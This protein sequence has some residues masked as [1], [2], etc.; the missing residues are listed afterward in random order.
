M[1]KAILIRVGIGVLAATALVV[2]V[3]LF[4][5]KS[6]TVTRS[7]VVNAPPAEIHLFTGDLN[8]W[9]EWT[10]WLNED[11]T[12]VVTVGQE[13]TGVGASQTWVGES[14]D[15][16]LT[17]TRSDPDWGIAYDMAFDQG[18]YRSQ[19]SMEYRTVGGATEVFWIMTGDHG[20]NPLERYFGIFMP[21]MIG[22]MF[23]EGLARLKLV[24]EKARAE[25]ETFPGG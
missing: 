11:P 25:G 13:T 7:V 16:E 22:P 15:G 12:I 18:K 9:P 3:A 6:Y 4:L 21:A 1:G 17:F 23:D 20:P 19:N 2:V 5:P 14:G 8:R 24:T 10:P